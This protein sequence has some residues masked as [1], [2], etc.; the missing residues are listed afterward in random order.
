MK[1]QEAKASRMKAMEAGGSRP[2]SGY[3]EI[4][5]F[6]DFESDHTHKA[7][8]NEFRKDMKDP[9]QVVKFYNYLSV[10][11][12]HSARFLPNDLLFYLEILK[13]Q[14]LFHSHKCRDVV[15]SKIKSMINTYIKCQVAL[16]Q[17]EKKE[18]QID[19]LGLGLFSE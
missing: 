16:Q 5:N 14:D 1:L 7:R 15:D 11:K 10:W 2:Y 18:L 19:I 8:E 17:G 4:D 12:T 6:Q 13:Y 3:T 9:A